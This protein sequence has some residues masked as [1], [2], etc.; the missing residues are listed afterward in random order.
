[1]TLLSQT[2]TDAAT[3]RTRTLITGVWEFALWDLTQNKCSIV[4]EPPNKHVLVTS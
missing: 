3:V 1:M 4:S 2:N